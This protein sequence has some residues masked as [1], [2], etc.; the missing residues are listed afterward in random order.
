MARAQ[1]RGTVRGFTLIELM[2]AIAI[3]A[4][5]AA[6]AF[7]SFQYTIR[8]NRVATTTNQVI[9]AVARGRRR[10]AARAVEGSA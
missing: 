5:L 6:I 4:I 8:S 3:V 7:P 9:A 10:S 2:V 1:T